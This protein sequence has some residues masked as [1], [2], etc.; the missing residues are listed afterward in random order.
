MFLIGDFLPRR[1]T[2]SEPTA[3]LPKKKPILPIAMVVILLLL[4][5]GFFMMK[6]KGKDKAKTEIALSDKDTDLDEFLTNTQN[7]LMYVRV[8]M[9]LRLRKDYDEAKFKAN[10][11][12][13]RDAV[14]V[15]LNGLPAND[16][17]DPKKRPQLKKAIAEAINTA[18]EGPLTDQPDDASPSPKKRRRGHVEKID[19]TPAPTD[20]ENDWDSETGPVLK[21]RFT[22]LATQ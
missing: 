4:G 22:S 17:T 11:G 3:V 6:G 5:G 19:P 7:P 21:V 16:V 10:L 9:T 20:K 14:L 2:M 13:V 8:K 12:D 18:L 15:V 1:I